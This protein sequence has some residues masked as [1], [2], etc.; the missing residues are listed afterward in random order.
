MD[1]FI[2]GVKTQSALKSVKTGKSRSVRLNPAIISAPE[3]SSFVHVAHVGINA[4][5]IVETS[6][7][8][9]PSWA[10]LIKDLHGYG[11]SQ[12][13]VVENLDFIEGFFAGAKRAKPQTS[14]KNSRTTRETISSKRMYLAGSLF[15]CSLTWYPST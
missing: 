9:D 1:F 2:A 8:I 12:D 10:V 13:L 5:G 14:L 6:K 11:I 3:P 4:D 7:D 15:Q